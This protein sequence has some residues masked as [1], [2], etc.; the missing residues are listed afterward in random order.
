MSTRALYVSSLSTYK[1]GV[2][3]H[4]GGSPVD[5]RLP[6][7]CRRMCIS[8]SIW[9]TG[10]FCSAEKTLSSLPQDLLQRT[11]GLT[12]RGWQVWK[13][14]CLP[15]RPS[16]SHAPSCHCDAQIGCLTL[17]AFGLRQCAFSTERTCQFMRLLYL[18]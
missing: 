4:S 3:R 14:G 16:C 15:R 8:E 17:E 5:H 2:E 18:Q 7:K 1:V 10:R 9:K 12:A 11:G 6:V 13:R